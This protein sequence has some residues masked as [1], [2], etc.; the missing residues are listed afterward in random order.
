MLES[1]WLEE[2]GDDKAF[3]QGLIKIAA[4]FHHYKKGTYQGMLDLLLAG[5]DVLNR[6]KPAYRGI[7]LRVFL[8]AVNEWI[9]IARRL[10]RGE[11]KSTRREIPPLVYRT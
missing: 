3:L 1:V 8:R 2:E 11:V 6:F 10:V 5:R 4:A 9:P 7:K